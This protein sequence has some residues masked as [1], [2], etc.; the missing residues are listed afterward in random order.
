MINLD[1]YETM[2]PAPDDRC[3]I[4]VVY[5]D[6]S[7]CA[8]E[9]ENLSEDGDK[10]SL[11]QLHVTSVTF[12]NAGKRDLTEHGY[13]HRFSDLALNRSKLNRPITTGRKPDAGH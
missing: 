9:C 2:V 12:T 10:K 7:L 4:F 6:A 13:C 5:A 1:L 11:G 8:L 3:F